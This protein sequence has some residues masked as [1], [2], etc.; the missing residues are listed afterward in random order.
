MKI[1]LDSNVIIAAFSDRGLCNSIFELCIEKYEILINSQII[2]ETSRIFRNK[3]KMPEENINAI[4]DYL[5]D[6][7]EFSEHEHISERVSRDKD[8]GIISLAIHNNA[9]YIIT[10]DKDLLVLKEYKSIS[11]VTPRKFW[12]IARKDYR[13]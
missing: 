8:D 2:E 11:I 9:G 12:E 3:F 7:C 4:V 1:V 10:G 13:I 6:S 5:K